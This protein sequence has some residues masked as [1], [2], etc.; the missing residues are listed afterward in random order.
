MTLVPHNYRNAD[1]K[2]TDMP[3][4]VR[5]KKKLIILNDNIK[6][7]QEKFDALCKKHKLDSF[8]SD[9]EETLA[10][11]E[12]L[13]NDHLS[14]GDL[15]KIID[16]V[17]NF[18]TINIING[19]QFYLEG[20]EYELDPPA[21]ELQN[22]YKSYLDEIFYEHVKENTVKIQNN[23][24]VIKDNTYAWIKEMFE[25]LFVACISISKN[26]SSD[27]ELPS[28]LVNLFSE[29]ISAVNNQFI[30]TDNTS[31]TNL[32][33][34]LEKEHPAW[35]SLLSQ[36]QQAINNIHM[37]T[38][39]FKGILDG[40]VEVKYSLAL[41]MLAC[42]AKSTN[43][44][45]LF[46]D[47][48]I[49]DAQ[50]TYDT[51]QNERWISR[52]LATLEM[53]VLSLEDKSSHDN[54]GTLVHSDKNQLLLLQNTFNSTRELIIH[55][56]N[57]L[58]NL[59]KDDP[60]KDLIASFY[61][62]LH[63]TNTLLKALQS[64]DM[65]LTTTGWALVLSGIIDFNAISKYIES[66]AKEWQTLNNAEIVISDK[67][68]D[69][70]K[71]FNASALTVQQTL[72]K[73]FANIVNKLKV[74]DNAVIRDSII[75]VINTSL[76]QLSVIQQDLGIA[77][78]NPEYQSLNSN[79]PTLQFQK[80]LQSNNSPSPGKQPR[81]I[82]PSTQGLFSTNPHKLKTDEKPPIQSQEIT[83]P[84]TEQEQKDFINTFS[85]KIS[86]HKG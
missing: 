53:K 66:Y 42:L 39:T 45:D 51:L 24:I 12:F 44:E 15:Y 25:R 38:A 9:N 65:L 57:V 18:L 14:R 68:N 63:K 79:G 61:V 27:F 64:I 84:E 49:E 17:Q 74:I 2:D 41:R 82:S 50:L 67:A 37:H 10:G 83:Y 20:H 36:M 30:L 60:N 80:R 77:I 3:H 7:L 8:A 85:Q 75:N 73:D 46:I 35:I 55:K 72:Q 31:V 70:K 78:I 71:I 76:Q 16:V 33:Y 54:D 26:T 21:Y 11:K 56:D 23:T 43:K 13:G 69:L 34:A 6:F 19:K 48:W 40:F 28:N 4:T 81:R 86:Q 59:S 32:S 58:Q 52:N 62:F 5:F 29:F 1:D 47:G 22:A